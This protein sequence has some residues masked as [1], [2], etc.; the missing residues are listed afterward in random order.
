MMRYL[1]GLKTDKLFVELCEEY[2]PKIVKYLYYMVGDIEEAKDL[3][4]EVFTIVYRK[5][6]IV[7]KHENQGGFIFQTAK[8][9]GANFKRKKFKQLNMERP[10]EEEIPGKFEDVGDEL[11]DIY[12]QR[13]DETS[14][15]ATVLNEVSKEKQQLYQWHYIDGKSYS[16]IARLLDMNEAS[17]RMRYVRLRREI[18]KITIKLAEEKFG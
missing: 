5:I 2:H 12:D 10:I 13:I 4:Q 18:K 6:E 14:Y 3:T 11:W 17:V 7:E 8:N 9:V 1:E 16:E 15:V